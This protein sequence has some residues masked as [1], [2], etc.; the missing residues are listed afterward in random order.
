MSV[1]KRNVNF[2]CFFFASLAYIF[3]QLTKM[4]TMSIT[5]QD[6]PNNQN[7]IEQAGKILQLA[8]AE[9]FPDAWSELE[10]GIE[11]VLEMLADDRICRVAL[12][13]GQI[14]GWIGGIPE[15]EGNVWELHPL[16]VHPDFQGRGIGKLLVQDLEKQVAEKGCL[17]LMLG[18]D[19]V[20]NMTTLSDVDL[21]DNL[22]EKIATI[23]NLKGHPFSF[24]QKLGFQIIGVMPDANGIGKPDI[25]MG[26]RIQ[27]T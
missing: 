13:E 15:Y 5:I 20:S 21:Y 18:S 23:Q 10:E 2:N 17:T 4:D 7:M 1:I 3:Y 9:N 14:V 6:M 27:P 8:F 25:F 24:Y 12:L 26:K 11:E 22:P 16:A 19:D